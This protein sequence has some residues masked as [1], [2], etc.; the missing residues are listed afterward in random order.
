MKSPDKKLSSGP[1]VK[2]HFFV[3]NR[4]GSIWSG[5]NHLLPGESL[6]L[7][8]V[9]AESP[10]VYLGGRPVFVLLIGLALIGALSPGG[11]ASL[12]SLL[13]LIWSLYLLMLGQMRHAS[14]LVTSNRLIRVGQFE[15]SFY[16]RDCQRRAVRSAAGLTFVEFYAAGADAPAVVLQLDGQAEQL[17][18]WLALLPGQIFALPPS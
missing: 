8:Q 3:G 9:L 15:Q 5:Q 7:A 13:L 1:V 12:P 4:Y 11:V 2:A 17:E 6:L 18:A 10:F 16:W 14:L